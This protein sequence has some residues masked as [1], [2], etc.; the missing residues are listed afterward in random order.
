MPLAKQH[1]VLV[2]GAGGF[3]GANLVRHLLKKGCTVHAVTFSQLPSWRLSDCSGDITIHRLDLRDAE[4]VA[5]LV[6]KVKPSFVY[7][8]ATHGGYHKQQDGRRIV[9]TNIMG[10]FNLFDALKTCRTLKRIVN[11]GSSSEYGSKSHPMKEQ[12]VL[13]PT[14][15]Y[16]VAKAAQTLL[17]QYLAREEALP[18]VTLRFFSV[19]GPFEEPGRLIAD[20]MCAVVRKRKLQLSSPDPKRDFVFVDDVVEALEKT[21]T[22]PG[23]EGEIFN[24]GSGK[25]HTVL[26]A[27]TL[28][29]EEAGAKT[30]IQWGI[31]RKQ[32]LYGSVRWVADIGK[33]KRTLQWKPRHS[34][35]DGLRKTYEWFR[36]NIQLYEKAE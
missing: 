17:A 16:G 20:V 12:D 6:K 35:A 4:R 21:M 14:T 30:D 2:T 36:E 26:D 24:I 15:A 13:E 22:L 33:A 25:E 9:H 7:H 3:I 1:S 11:A 5:A 8:L 19:Y 28:A 18:L 29:M 23:I 34:L 31:K 27:V 32:R 10:S